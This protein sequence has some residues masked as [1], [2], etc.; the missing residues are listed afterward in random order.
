MCVVSLSHTHTVYH[1]HTHI[2]VRQVTM[3]VPSIETGTSKDKVNTREV[4][5]MIVSFKSPRKLLITPKAAF[6][7]FIVGDFNE[8]IIY[9][10]IFERTMSVLTQCGSIKQAEKQCKLQLLQPLTGHLTPLSTLSI[11]VTPSSS[12]IHALFK[13]QQ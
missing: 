12:H 4:S 11:E 8:I 13:Q 6:L 10:S 9:Y 7:F 3:K 2:V 1:Y 5:A